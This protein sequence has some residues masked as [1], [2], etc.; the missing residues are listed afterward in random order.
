MR[1]NTKIPNKHL[2]HNEKQITNNN[3]LG[4]TLRIS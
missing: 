1:L 4:N 2:I 3:S